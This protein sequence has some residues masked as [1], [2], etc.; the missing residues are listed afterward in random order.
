MLM[1]KYNEHKE[2]NLLNGEKFDTFTQQ[3]A[4][5]IYDIKAE[6]MSFSEFGIDMEEDAFLDTL[7]I[8]Q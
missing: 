8:I 2:N 7:V 1:E 5:L 3:L 6:M 4:C